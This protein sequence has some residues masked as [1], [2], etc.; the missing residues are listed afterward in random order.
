M[1]SYDLF[2]I[3][4]GSGGVRAARIAA[5]HG[6]RVALAE[7][8]RIGGTCVIRGCVPKKLMVLAARFGDAFADSAAFGWTH[9]EA[10]FDWTAFRRNMHR[11]IDRLNAAY[12]KNLDAAGVTIIHDHATVEG[13]GRVRLR[14][15]GEN[16]E[17]RNILIATGGHANRLPDI[18]GGELA[19]VS[20]AMFEL[21]R[22]PASILI[23]GA[24]YVAIEFA[25]VM[26]GLG[27]KT[28]LLQRGSAILTDFDQDVRRE[29]QAAMERR[30]V[31]I[32]LRDELA[33]IDRRDAGLLA[34]TREGRDFPAE[35]VL[36][37]I[38]RTPNTTGIGL[39]EAGVA[40]DGEG[41]VIVDEHSQSTAPGIFAIGDVTN[42]LALT[43]VAIREGHTLAD[44]L[45]GGG[46]AV[47]D[48]RNV[49]HAVFGTPEIGCV[50]LGEEEARA[51]HPELDI[52]QT[53]FRPMGA[54]LAGSDEKMMMKL[55]VDATTDRVLGC[56]IIGPDGAEMVQ[57]VAIAVKMGA[58]K[59][60]FDATMALHPTAAEELV[61]MREPTRRHRREAKE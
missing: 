39:E 14:D 33:G 2:V 18:P 21:E 3:G 22:L 55:V 53:S 28:T 9:G 44:R 20:D 36:L 42:K 48:H 54:Q 25:S 13:P 47:V 30:G 49:P 10:K 32:V 11:E 31:E 59:A 38:G 50:G 35:T 40:L 61:T 26:A 52:Y 24:G 12:I 57:M 29:M 23:V 56:H 43:P 27:V 16:V 60:D 1:T 51:E 6:A 15:A 4:G 34:R 45:F 41:S 46:T 7:H 8:D 19:I 5:R 17:A 58:A 37:A